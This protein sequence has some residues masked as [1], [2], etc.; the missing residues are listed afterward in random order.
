MVSPELIRF[1]HVQ[2]CEWA[3]ILTGGMEAQT[4]VLESPHPIGSSTYADHDGLSTSI[5]GETMATPEWSQILLR[6][7]RKSCKWNG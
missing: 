2:I 1:M 6:N 7:P 4:P 3:F 5:E